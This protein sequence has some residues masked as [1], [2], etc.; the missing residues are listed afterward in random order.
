VR[1]VGSAEMREIDRTA[2]E[3]FG[4]PSL[5]LMERAGRA[6]AEAALQLAAPGGRFVAVCGA[7]NNGGDGYVAARLLR[8][9]GRDSRVLALV[10]AERLSPD[11]RAVREQARHAGVA[12]DDAGE[13]AAVEA[14]PGDVVLDA[15]F[16]TGLARPPLGA[17]AGAISR[18]EAARAAGARVLAV[19]V[20]S[21]LSADTGRPLGACVRADRTVTF[22]FPKRGLVLFPGASLAGEVT[23]ADIGIPA[24]AARRVP[25]ECELLAEAEAR[26]LVPPRA[27]DAHKGDAGRLLVVAGSGG[28]TGAAHLALTGALRGGAGLVTLAA[29]PEVMPLALAGR[30]EAMSAAIP[31]AGPLGRADLQALLAA[32]KG[33]DAVVVGPGIPRGPETGELLCALLQRAGKPAVV[34]ADGLN[35][36]AEA[37]DAIAGLGVPLVLTPHPGEMARLCGTAIDVIQGDRI[38][39]AAAKARAWKATVVL[40]GA[41]TIVADPEAP[42]A[43]IPTGNAG[44]ATGGTGDVLAGL[45]GA[46]L[47]GGLSAPAAARAGA[48]VHGRAGDLA[49][50]RFGERGLVAGDLGEAI[51]AVWA[52]WR[53]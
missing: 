38:G 14:G 45:C 1:L 12:I 35:A 39:I 33:V 6:V 20:P 50:R 13:L 48:F 32:A 49:A 42:P 52:E 25:A 44:L 36:L 21:G 26:L 40:K 51:G 47:A 37:P 8:D 18:I 31:G 46:L 4:I 9:A 24:E 2:I 7:G 15:I 11:A 23:V 10:P 34:D 30:P 22:A 17:F 43:V 28:K 53:R 19:D 41:R 3:V 16:G 27:P 5:T 29:R